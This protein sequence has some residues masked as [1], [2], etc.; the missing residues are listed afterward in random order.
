MFSKWS[1]DS[2]EIQDHGTQAP[3][4]LGTSSGSNNSSLENETVSSSES[5]R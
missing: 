4:F 5:E 3:G 2:P 1:W